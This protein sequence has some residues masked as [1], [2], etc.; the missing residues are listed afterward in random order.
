MFS[1]SSSSENQFQTFKGE[2]RQISNKN[3]GGWLDLVY[4]L[5]CAS[6][7]LRI[8]FYGLERWHSS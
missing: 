1:E 6:S 3:I 5:Q 4:E 7:C 8:L 2:D